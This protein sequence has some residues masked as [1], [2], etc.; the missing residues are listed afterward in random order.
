MLHALCMS[1]KIP[2]EF[3]LSKVKNETTILEEM[4]VKL[5]YSFGVRNN[6]LTMVNIPLIRAV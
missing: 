5:A 4:V 1:G 2:K 3:Q 6:F